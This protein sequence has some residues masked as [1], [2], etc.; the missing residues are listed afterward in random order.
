MLAL[1]SCTALGL[2]VVQNLH[3]AVGAMVTLQ[4]AVQKSSFQLV[5][6]PCLLSLSPVCQPIRLDQTSPC[7]GAWVV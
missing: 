5:S 6:G 4:R 3:Q 1:L 7:Q 2:Q